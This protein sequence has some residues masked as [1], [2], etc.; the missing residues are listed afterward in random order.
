MFFILQVTKVLGL[1][2]IRYMCVHC[3]LLVMTDKGKWVTVSICYIVEWQNWC[4]N[5][6]LFPM[7]VMT[8][9][10]YENVVITHKRCYMFF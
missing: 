7:C 1:Y 2:T 9:C 5:N 3:Y 8:V 10:M 4:R 6:T